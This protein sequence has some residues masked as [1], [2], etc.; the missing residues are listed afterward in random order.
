M[1]TTVNTM[2]AAVNPDLLSVM[3]PTKPKYDDGS[4]E[5]ATDKFM[6]LLVT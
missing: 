4:V 1:A 3:N 6:T 5:A 2:P